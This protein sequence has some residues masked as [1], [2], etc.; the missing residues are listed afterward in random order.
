MEETEK[1][2]FYTTYGISVKSEFTI[3]VNIVV[4]DKLG[5]T[6]HEKQFPIVVRSQKNGAFINDF[7]QLGTVRE[8]TNPIGQIIDK[9]TFLEPFVLPGCNFGVQI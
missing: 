8:N 7:D 4:R 5:E 2:T 1:F 3:D 9:Y 6:T